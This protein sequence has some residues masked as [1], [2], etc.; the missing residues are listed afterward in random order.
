MTT[1]K[2]GGGSHAYR[3]EYGGGG[4]ATTLALASLSQM[5][6]PG[7]AP[8]PEDTQHFRADATELIRHIQVSPSA[9]E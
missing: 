4:G 9:K 2:H 5:S 1:V 6:R 7:V 8:T 3:E